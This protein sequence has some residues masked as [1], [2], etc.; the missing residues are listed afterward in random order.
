MELT[1]LAKERE[2]IGENGEKT[3]R[4]TQISV[5]RKHVAIP[6]K[7]VETSLIAIYSVL[8]GAHRHLFAGRL[9]HA[10]DF[11]P[12]NWSQTNKYEHTSSPSFGSSSSST[13]LALGDACPALS[14]S[15]AHR[16]NAN[17]RRRSSTSGSV[18]AIYLN[19]N[20]FAK[21]ISSN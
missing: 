5:C 10:L 14:L 3:K 12:C 11:L 17:S 4:L 16:Q 15:P 9:T 13:T 1:C 2:R 19:M 8:H 20:Y 6:S 7:R 21:I 18:P